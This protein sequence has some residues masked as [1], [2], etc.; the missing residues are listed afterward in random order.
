M[1]HRVPIEDSLD[2]HSFRP[3]DIASVLDEYVSL[4]IEAGF[5]LVRVIHG[6]GRGVQRAIVQRILDAHPGVL[7]FWD[8][9]AAH[10]GATV[11][12]LAPRAR[13]RSD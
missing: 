8:D 3:R 2:L 7:E 6:R 10:L 4:A 13:A 5:P 11:A 1:T 9:T 12:R